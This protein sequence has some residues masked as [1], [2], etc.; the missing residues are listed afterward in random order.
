MSSVNFI[1]P[2]IDQTV[3]V[4]DEFYRYDVTIPAAEYDIVY[5][6]FLNTMQN[7]Q[8]AGNFAVSLFKVA[9]DTGIPALTLLQGFEGLDSVELNANLAYYLNQIRSRAT[10]LGV[11]VAVVPNAYAARLVVQ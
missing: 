8:S 4:F 3:R 9:E 7:Q 1:N 10:L 6:F 11:N 2:N 5:S